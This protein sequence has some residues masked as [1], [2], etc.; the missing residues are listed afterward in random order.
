ME[1]ELSVPPSRRG[2]GIGLGVLVSGLAAVVSIVLIGRAWAAC[3]VGVNAS[4][5]GMALLVLAP[6][7]W[8]ATAVVWVILYSTLGRLHPTLALTAGL[9]FTLCSTWFVVTWLGMPDSYPSP[10]PGSVPP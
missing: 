5:N 1:A 3:D 6:L 4:A 10:C 7:I 9:I 2:G 8:I